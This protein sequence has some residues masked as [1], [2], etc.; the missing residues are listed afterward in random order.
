MK[1][2]NVFFSIYMKNIELVDRGIQEMVS[3]F[4]EFYQHD[5][6]T[7]Y[8]MT[9]DHGMTDWGEISSASRGRK[10]FI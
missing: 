5:E 2:L 7:S 9:A 10:C 4:E 6:K 1:I 3:L 8:I